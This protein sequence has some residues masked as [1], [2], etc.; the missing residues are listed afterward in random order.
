M[1]TWSQ[2]ALDKFGET[3]LP[4]LQEVG[5]EVREPMVEQVHNIISG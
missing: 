5:L 4:I 3:L 1:S 2:E